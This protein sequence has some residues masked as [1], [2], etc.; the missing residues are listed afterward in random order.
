MTTLTSADV[1]KIQGLY[2]DL[3]YLQAQRKHIKD[4]SL[5]TVLG[6]TRKGTSGV[7]DHQFRDFS[8]EG[9]D[10]IRKVVASDIRRRAGKIVDTLHGYGC[11]AKLT[12]E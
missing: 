2:R 5:T 1:T 8:P 11:E 3:E 4:V 9:A 10:E 12:E 7:E 6:Q